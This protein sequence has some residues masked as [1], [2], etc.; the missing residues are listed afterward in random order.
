LSDS[1][2]DD[3]QEEQRRAELEML[4]MDDTS[5]HAKKKSSLE[6][7]GSL[8]KGKMSKRARIKL[9]KMKKRA[10]REDGSDN[11]D[12]DAQ[13]KEYLNMDDPRFKEVFENPEFALDPTD[14]R[15]AKSGKAATKLATEVAKRRSQKRRSKATTDTVEEY[16]K[17]ID[18]KSSDKA[19]IKLM[20]ASLK[21]KSASTMNS[22]KKSKPSRW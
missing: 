18:S 21:R 15:F 9:A 2:D 14:P 5:L 22:K 3:A 10:E 16:D 19:D 17:K 7:D 11:E 6:K 4:L 8:P 20:V 13:N 1:D 12:L